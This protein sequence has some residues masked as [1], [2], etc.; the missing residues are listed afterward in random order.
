MN[1][2]PESAKKVLRAIIEL[3]ESGERDPSYE[4]VAA[5]V[6]I[7]IQGVAYH[8]RTLE[9]LGYAEKRTGVRGFIVHRDERGRPYKPRPSRAEL[10]AAIDRLE[11]PPEEAVS[12]PVI[13]YVGAGPGADLPPPPLRSVCFPRR[14]GHAELA[15]FCVAGSSMTGDD[16]RPGDYVIV[17][18][19][20]RV[21]PLEAAVHVVFEPGSGHTLKRI[22]PEEGEVL[23]L[24]SNRKVRPRKALEGSVAQGR[25]VGLY[26]QL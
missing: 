24:S 11:H 5:Q 22:R 3:E 20:D 7:T 8:T 16:I 12:V 9:R 6:G 4:D 13:G 18:V 25:V 19:T 10:R 17:E 21:D 14:H 15:A 2:L 26:R 1:D 23:L